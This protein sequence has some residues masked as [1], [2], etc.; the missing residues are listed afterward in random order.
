MG[1]S[2]RSDHVLTNPHKTTIDTK[3]IFISTTVISFLSF[4]A[5]ISLTLSLMISSWFSRL[6]ASLRGRLFLKAHTLSKAR[7]DSKENNI[8]NAR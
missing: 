6:H 3:G 5:D 1:K 7:T 4:S 8:H 2:N